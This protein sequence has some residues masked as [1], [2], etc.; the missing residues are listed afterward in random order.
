MTTLRE[1]AQQSEVS[2]C[3]ASMVLSGREAEGRI[4]AATA[5]RVR[6]VARQLGYRH[7]AHARSL[8]AKKSNV[9]GIVYHS[10]SECHRRRAQ[11]AA[12]VLGDEGFDVSMQDLS[13][14]PE[15]EAGV[16]K[17]LLSLRVEGLLLESGAGLRPPGQDEARQ[18]LL[19]LAKR[20][21]P[22]VCFGDKELPI[23]VVDSDREEAVFM[24]TSH[25]L[26]LGHKAIAYPMQKDHLAPAMQARWRGFQKAHREAGVAVKEVLLARPLDES[27]L[28]RQAIHAF[29]YG[30]R[31]LPKILILRPRP[32]ALL[33]G[34][35]YAALG[36]IYAAQEKGIR[37]PDDLAVVAYSGNA[38]S[39][40][41][42]NLLPLTRVSFPYEAMGREAVRMLQERM[43]GYKGEPR[44]FDFAPEL[45][46]RSTC[47]VSRQKPAR[48]KQQKAET[49]SAV[50]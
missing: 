38:E 22:L 16:F 34:D 7:N 24:A 31:I 18:M 32:T 49:F 40:E 12:R 15:R 14:R 50:Q 41:E 19:K 36:A 5:E 23:D 35:E 13:W 43:D 10:Y 33:I 26:K 6:R 30:Y 17:E 2:L 46:V 1:I 4:A 44:R 48:L 37:V 27:L 3:T 11:A 20:G 21:F 39:E 42:K 29:D 8:R 25:L 45:I 28:N 47:G 9:V